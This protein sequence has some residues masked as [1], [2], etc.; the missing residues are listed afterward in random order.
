MGH[1]MDGTGD[2]RGDEYR[3]PVSGT[4]GIYTLY[5]TPVTS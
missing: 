2:P 5:H 4:N 3:E 1:A